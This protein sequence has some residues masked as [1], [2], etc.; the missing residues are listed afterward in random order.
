M[1]VLSI[2]NSFSDDAQTYLHRIAAADGY[3][4]YTVNLNIGGCSLQT[5]Y[6]NM[7]SNEKKYMF[8][9]NGIITER[10]VSFEEGLLLEDWDVVTLQQVSRQSVI[11]DSFYPYIHEIASAVRHLAPNAK[12]LIHQTWAYEAG[13]PAIMEICGDPTPEYMHAVSKKAYMRAKN[14][15]NADAIIPS[16]DLFIEYHKQGIA[17]IHRDRHHASF[18]FGRY[19][20]ALLC[21]RSLTGRS[22]LDISFSDFDE[23]VSPEEIR[24]AKESVEAYGKII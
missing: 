18:G 23:P 16:G 3:D 2:G 19:A 1:K 5:H 20:L 7:I 12:L 14:E 9:E 11:E 8:Q 17:N 15:I 21:Y 6:N 13:A 4:M 22:V 10:F 24:L